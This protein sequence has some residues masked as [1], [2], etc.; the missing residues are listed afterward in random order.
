MGADARP[1]G[2]AERRPFRGGKGH[3]E[4][5]EGMRSSRKLRDKAPGSAWV[6]KEKGGK[7]HITFFCYEAVRLDIVCLSIDNFDFP[8]KS[9]SAVDNTDMWAIPEIAND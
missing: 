2:K 7:K 1:T 4:F 3:S 5:V 8:F 6:P 9:K